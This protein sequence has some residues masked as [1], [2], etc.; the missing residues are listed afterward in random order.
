MKAVFIPLESRF[1]TINR[2]DY[3]KIGYKSM[4]EL[5][6]ED[7]IKP[8]DPKTFAYTDQKKSKIIESLLLG[9]PQIFQ[10]VMHLNHDQCQERVIK[11]H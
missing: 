10:I 6:K 4:M 2:S 3:S 11:C 9:Y 8:Y 5:A 1:Y 7:K